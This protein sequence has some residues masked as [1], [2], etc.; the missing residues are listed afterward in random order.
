MRVLTN[1]LEIN[2]FFLT[3]SYWK[4]TMHN[5]FQLKANIVF[6]LQEASKRREAN[7]PKEWKSI[8]SSP[9]E[10]RTKTLKTKNG[11]QTFK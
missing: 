5:E 6:S 4:P 8:Q 3:T 11:N 1:N 2:H 7:T 9:P 10:K